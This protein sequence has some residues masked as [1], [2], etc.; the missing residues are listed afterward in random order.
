[1][2]M[3]DDKKYRDN[4]LWLFDE[5]CSAKRNRETDA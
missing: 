3:T 4:L 5:R 1:M 2:N